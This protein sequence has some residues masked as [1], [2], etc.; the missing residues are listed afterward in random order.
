MLRRFV[1]DES[2]HRYLLAYSQ[3]RGIEFMS[4]PF[5]LGGVDLLTKRLGVKRVKIASGEIVNGPLLLH[6]AQDGV[7]IILSTG[8]STLKEVEEALGVIAFGYT[9]P[10]GKPSHT[11]FHD[12]FQ[13]IEGQRSL[14]DKVTLLHCTTEY[15]TPDE[16]VNLRAMDTLMQTF[17]LRV[18]LSDHSKGIEVPIA[19]VAR[20]ASVIEKHLTVSRKL[21]GPD[22][23]ASLEP[24]EFGAMVSG[25]RKVE[26]ALGSG[27]KKPAPCEVKNIAI[28]RKSLVA[29]R[30][31][32]RGEVLSS[33]NIAIKRAGIGISPMDYWD[34]MGKLAEYDFDIDELIHI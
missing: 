17:G 19:A 32:S 10:E 28:V 13:S 7:L 31:I 20:G 23:Q 12:A 1:L 6:V 8:M 24:D 25:I 21:P 11:A 5:F 18:G 2:A 16:G 9:Q 26:R 14:R 4:T 22:H 3:E 27:Q 34:W 29:A 30:P 33:E 15:P